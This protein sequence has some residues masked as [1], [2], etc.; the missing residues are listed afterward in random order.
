MKISKKQRAFTLTELLVVIVIIGVL[1]SVAIPKFNRVIETRRASEA[2]EILAAIR[3]EQEKRCE[4]DKQYTGYFDKLGGIVPSESET[5]VTQTEA[6]D[7][8][9]LASGA[10]ATRNEAAKNYTLAMP[11]YKD[12]RLCCDG[13]YCINFNKNYPPCDELFGRSDYR[14]ADAAC[15]ADLCEVSKECAPNASETRQCAC[16]S[17]TRMCDAACQWGGWSGS[18]Y[19]KTGARTETKSCQELQRNWRGTATRNCEATCDGRGAC[20]AWNTS[21]CSVCRSETGESTQSRR[22]A[23]GYSGTQTRTW[24]TNTC[25]WGEWAGVCTCLPPAGEPTSRA[26]EGGKVGT[27]TRTWNASS[28]TW[29]AWQGECRANCSDSSYKAANKAECCP[30]AAQSDNVCYQDCNCGLVARFTE[31]RKVVSTSMAACRLVNGQCQWA[32]PPERGLPSSC[33]SSYVLSIHPSEGSGTCTWAENP[34]GGGSGCRR[35]EKGQGE[36]C[37]R[38]AGAQPPNYTVY[39]Q[40]FV[41]EN[42]CSRCRN[43]W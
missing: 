27:Q 42:R 43:G 30:S 33:S 34:R 8:R 21:D 11:S 31:N 41:V 14:P 36:P 17:Q 4:L 1:S 22:C 9:L 2:E 18:C 25:S 35:N 12:G 37:Y 16:G 28:C 40:N 20:P 23:T 5:P 7:Y 10:S 39:K 24:N 15:L 13:A 29:G 19:E 38:Y 6:Y 3:M 32:V 26:C